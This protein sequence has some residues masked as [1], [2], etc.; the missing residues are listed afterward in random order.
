MKALD[1]KTIDNVNVVKNE[2]VKKHY[3][4]HFKADTSNGIIFINTKDYVKK[5]GSKEVVSVVVN[6]KNPQQEATEDAE[7]P[8]VF[9]V[10]ENMPEFPGGM[11]AMMQFLAENVCYPEAAEKSG[12]QGR[13]IATFI[14]EKDGSITNIKIVKSVSKE[15]DAE[16]KRVIEAMPNWK[17]GKQNGEPVRVK[18]TIPITFRLSSPSPST[19]NQ[20]A[21]PTKPVTQS[22][23]N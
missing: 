10:V 20:Q 11:T 3:A 9:D 16:A 17:P 19:Q 15:L 6:A 21:E 1:P 2:E 14:V 13:V 18:Y 23:S 8:K 12:T 4:A 5:G 7:M 22:T